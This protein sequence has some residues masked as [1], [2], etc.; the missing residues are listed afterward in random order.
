MTKA[1]TDGTFI[2][3]HYNNNIKCKIDPKVFSENIKS[4][5]D[6][7]DQVKPNASKYIN[8]DKD[9][10]VESL[11]LDTL[12]KLENDEFKKIVKIGETASDGTPQGRARNAATYTDARSDTFKDYNGSV[13]WER[14][15]EGIKA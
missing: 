15:S 4:I 6:A 7:V 10:I 9:F 11:L 5:K 14:I 3:Q 1:N 2:V 12:F 8:N 13:Q